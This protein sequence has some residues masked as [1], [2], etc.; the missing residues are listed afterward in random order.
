MPEGFEELFK[1]QDLADLIAYVGS[2][3]LPPKIFQGNRPEV[4]SADPE[5][6]IRLLASNGE[7]Y[8]DSLV[9]ESQYGNLGFWRSGND[10]AVWT[11]KV[12]EGKKYEV[13]LDWACATETAG[14]SFQ[15]QVE[16]TRLI[17]KVPGTGTWDNYKHDTFG[18]LELAPG[19]HRLSFRAEGE[20]RNCLMDLREVRLV[21][22]SRK[23][24]PQFS[25]GR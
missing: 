9:L 5:G 25:S 3:G 13:W 10:R 15:I 12:T 14:N 11:F 22:S 19:Q 23:A 1:A 21:P 6:Q 8:G 2:V 18:Q 17:D 16:D 20:I 24:P 7:I 4:A